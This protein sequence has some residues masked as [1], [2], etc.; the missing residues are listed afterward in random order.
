MDSETRKLDPLDAARLPG[1]SAPS[2]SSTPVGNGPA[3]TPGNGAPAPFSPTPAPGGIPTTGLPPMAS[4][5]NRSYP[6]PMVAPRPVAPSMFGG[7]NILPL[8]LIVLGV[9]LFTGQ[10]SGLNTAAVF[11][12]AI[13]L[14]IGLV[15]LYVYY[16]QGRNFGFL[17]PGAIMTGLGAGI[18][19]TTIMGFSGGWVPLGLGLGFCA[20]WFL[21]RE[22]W[23]ALIPGGIISLAGLSTLANSGEWGGNL[24]HGGSIWTLVLIGV[25]VWLL[26]SRNNSWRRH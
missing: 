9:L 24:F 21:H 15:F 18:V 2:T 7:S 20:I 3:P 4:N 25:G 16:A 10:F 5:G 26:A 17:V 8:V 6:S 11:G 19:T 1:A 12:S 13:V 14:V 22:H 23:W